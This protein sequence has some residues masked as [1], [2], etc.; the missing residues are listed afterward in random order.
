MTSSIPRRV[1][2]VVQRHVILRAK[3]HLKGR[4]VQP[5]EEPD[6]SQ[7][8]VTPRRDTQNQVSSTRDTHGVASLS[9][10]QHL[11]PFSA[12]V[13]FSVST[14]TA[15]VKPH[16]S[17]HGSG[18]SLRVLYIYPMAPLDAVNS[19]QNLPHADS[20]PPWTHQRFYNRV[21]NERSLVSKTSYVFASDASDRFST[22][23]LFGDSGI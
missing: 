11:I 14:D 1:R 5:P 10:C 3:P 19:V 20:T 9:S 23:I 21:Q 16:E 6:R 12:S 13:S 4:L 22:L 2:S 17:S 7:R 18:E 15:S 8:A